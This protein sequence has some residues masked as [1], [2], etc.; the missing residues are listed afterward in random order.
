M[1]KQLLAKYNAKRDFKKTAE[2]AGKLAKK[3][4]HS[5]LIQKHAALR[6]HYDFR[7]EL[8]GV[9]KSWAVT[10]GPSL[11]PEVRR[12]AVEVEDHP[13]SYGTFEG[14]I[15]KGQYGGGTVMLWDQG[16]WEPIGDPHKSLKKGHLSFKLHGKRLHGEWALV[17][18]HRREGESRNN[19][20]LIKKGDDYSKPGDQDKFLAKENTSIISKR[21]MEEIAKQK[22][23]TWQSNRAEKPETEEKNKAEV[24]IG[25]DKF[26]GFI[27]PQLATLADEMPKGDAWV[28]EVKFDGYRMQAHIDNGK[29]KLFT[30]KG[31]DWTAKFGSIAKDLKKLNI[32][33]AVLDGEIVA[34]NPEG[35]SSFIELQKKLKTGDDS[36]FQY[37]AFDLLHL[38]GQ[39]LMKLPLLERKGKLEEILSNKKLTQTFY[40]EHFTKAGNFYE[41]ACKMHL[42]GVISKLAKESYRTGRG[43]DWLKSKCHMR[44]E[45]AIGGYTKS[46]TGASVIG[47]LLLGY[48]KGKDFVY[49]GRVGTGFSHDLAKDIFKK[50]QKIKLDS[51]PYTKYSDNGRRGAGWKRGVV[52]VKPEYVCEV[53]FT[54][55]T[56]EGSLRHP[57]FQGLREDKPAKEIKRDI[58]IKANKV[59]KLKSKDQ[60][61]VTVAGIKISNPQREVYPGTGF[62]KQM[63]AEYYESVSDYILPYIEN[64]L[65]SAIRCTDGINGQCFFQRHAGTNATKDIHALKVKGHGEG[66]PYMYIK[67][68]RGLVS[69]AQ[70]G[71]IEIHP[72]GSNIKDVD[73]PDRIIFDLDPDPSV[74]WQKVMEG[75]AEIKLRLDDLGLESYLKTTGGK[76]LH[77]MIPIKPKYNWDVMKPW[78][79]AFAE[80]LVKDSPQ[81]YIAN[82]SKDKRKGKIFIDYLRNGLT[83]TAI[84]AYS[85]RS[86]EG[87]TVA[88]P[89]DWRQLNDKLDPKEYTIETVP[90]IIGRRKY[91]PWAEFYKNKQSI[92]ASNLKQ[93]KIKA[94]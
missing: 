39:N 9:L 14:I 27:K 78:A 35:V 71:V 74:S 32:K 38:N 20:L 92:S 47:S 70:M 79:K 18:M 63:I 13:V 81:K 77:V 90:G 8:D 40:S 42:E 26:P 41:Q 7:L 6:L 54:E 51:M 1:A 55:W 76:G 22:T 3:A 75:A 52:W 11:D 30:R 49:A 56:A 4:G 69:L 80:S 62:T 46:T 24:K 82:M 17:R 23:K 50:L 10:K 15:P 58:P 84:A 43:R 73:K 5:Y 12:L 64:R 87:A 93:F 25:K 60:T 66:K 19:W 83:S 68:K 48:Y 67:D 28:H 34:L 59:E 72:W 2:P 61:N 29:V 65:L 86:R 94:E 37:Y 53:E 57:S 45:F 31:L 44:Q 33:S 16:S 21:S 36:G 91:D 89:L 85:L 88:M